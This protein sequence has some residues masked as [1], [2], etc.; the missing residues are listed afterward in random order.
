MISQR[1]RTTSIVVA[2]AVVWSTCVGI[3]TATAATRS[4]ALPSGDLRL[5]NHSFESGLDGWTVSCPDGAQATTER[6]VS[7]GS[8][9][10][11]TSAGCGSAVVSSELLAAVA[12]ERYTAFV[13]ASAGVGDSGT[14]AFAFYD[15]SRQKITVT[16]SAHSAVAAADGWVTVK[17]QAIAPKGTKF[18]SV[19]LGADAPSGRPVYLDDVLVSRQFTT[20]GAQLSDVF[21][22]TATFTND[23]AGRALAYVVTDGAKNAPAQLVEIDVDSGTLTRSVNL[24]AGSPAGSWASTTAADGTIY[25]A[26]FQPGMLWSY[27]PGAAKAT[28]LAVIPS[29]Q[30]PFALAAGPGGVVY[31]GGYPD[32]IVY[33]Y[34][35]GRSGVIPYINAKKLTGQQYVRSLAVD[36]TTRTLYVGVGTRAGVLACGERTRICSNVLPKALRG[37]QFAYQLAAAPGKVFVYLS[38]SNDLAVLNVTA[39]PDG[40]YR[41]AL[42]ARISGVS[43]PGASAPVEGSVYYRGAAGKLF[44]YDLASGATSVAAASFP[45]T[46]GW[47]AVRLQDQTRYPG[48][49]LLAATGSPGGVD[50][51][52]YNL[53]TGK[54]SRTRIAD[55]A[56]APIV[57]QSI[58]RGPDGHVYSGGYL[59]GG[60]ASYAPMR[61]PGL[62]SLPGVGQPESMTAVGDTLY[63][64]TYPNAVIK[65]YQP[66]PAG[67]AGDGDGDD[68]GTAEE[69]VAPP[70]PSAAA[71]CTLRAQGQD[72]PYA[73]TEGGGKVYIGTAAGYGQRKGS[74]A[75]YD[76]A[77]G[78]CTVKRDIVKD[79]SIVSLL[80]ANGIVYGGSLVWGGLGVA[81]SQR[82]AKLLVYNAKTGASKAVPLPVQSASVE[83]LVVGPGGNIWMMA[84]N[85]L[86]IYSPKAGKFVSWQRLF[87]ELNYPGPPLGATSRVS[88]YDAFL[89][90]GGDG[91]IYGTIHN[92]YLFR[93]DTRTRK[94]TVLYAGAVGGLTTDTFGNIY[95][96]RGGNELARYVP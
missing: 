33:R 54:V 59:A 80:Y 96:I 77:T 50:I 40:T 2:A 88:A 18:L 8:A 47:G 39:M 48:M 55:L 64:G 84:Q 78:T 68:D 76:P 69:P 94:P 29:A 63:L 90:V 12:G 10:A 93:I 61:G 9:L 95:F 71:V 81:P 30:V 32:G 58:A 37:Q 65:T 11:L 35:P 74:L 82:Q 44:S 4:G 60:L 6:H 51:T 21:V 26:S 13:R 52:R 62:T 86:I 22:R 1:F 45:G 19:Q 36:G 92:R 70:A 20:L 49:T 73:M 67:P 38:P 25:V 16:K 42:A 53:A 87:P 15:A 14:V 23:K 56:G 3:S 91:Q 75:I 28:R 66:Q 34:V 72:R 46:R 5:A 27:K 83:G 85:W 31:I 79:Q 17:A 43:Y 57:I 7:G 41:G 24:N 89:T